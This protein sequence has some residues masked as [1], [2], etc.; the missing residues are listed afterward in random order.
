M[1]LYTEPPAASNRFR[2]EF[3]GQ[4]QALISREQRDADRRRKQFFRPDL[5]S[6][7]AYENSARKYRQ[8]FRAMLGWPLN[9]APEGSATALRDTFVARDHLGSIYRLWIDSLPG[10]ET[11]GLLFVPPSPG[12]HPLVLVQHGGLGTPELCS[13]FYG[14]SNYNG[15]TRRVLRR[16]CVVFAP[17]LLRWDA[18]YGDQQ[19][20]SELDRTLNQLGGSIAAVELL[21]IQRSLDYLVTRAEVD[22]SRVG[23]IG[24]SYGGFHTLFAAALDTRIQVALSSCF[25][26]DRK[27]YAFSDWVWFDAA[28]RFLDAEVAGLVCPRP[29]CIEVAVQDELFDVQYARPEATK[30]QALYERLGVPE[31][32]LYREH[33][34]VHELDRA[35][36]GIDF[37]F[38]HL[39]A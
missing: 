21:C 6:L 1:D 5:S 38:H 15:M 2:N 30:V 34:G 28:S 7:S 25:F 14:P 24:L 33:P 13:G 4:I 16:E 26:N 37:L 10:L 11:Y 27:R 31:R 35:D 23:M 17:Q 29:L 36:D 12:P 20:V 19:D 39:Q 18:Q 8:Q 22:P 3:L 32:F 9:V